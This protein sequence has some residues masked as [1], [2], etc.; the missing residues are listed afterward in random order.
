MLRRRSRCGMRLHSSS[1]LSSL[2]STLPQKHASA[3]MLRCGPASSEP[4]QQV[5]HAAA[6]PGP[7]LAHS[8]C[9]TTRLGKTAGEGVPMCLSCNG[10]RKSA[11]AQAVIP[12]QAPHAVWVLR[13]APPLHNCRQRSSS[14]TARS[15]SR[16]CS[17]SSICGLNAPAP[18]SGSELYAVI[19]HS[20]RRRAFQ[21]ARQCALGPPAGVQPGSLQGRT[22]ACA[23]ARPRQGP[24]TAPA[25]QRSCRSSWAAPAA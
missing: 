11:R 19:A 24:H 13:R 12:Q 25:A 4:G 6:A 7:H 8:T 16:A 1:M 17:C 22:R 20:M 21:N 2:L 18:S 15:A 23:L 10:L 3:A 9:A 14:G 5:A